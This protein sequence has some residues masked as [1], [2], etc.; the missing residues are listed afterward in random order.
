[1]TTAPKLPGSP[2]TGPFDSPSA[3]SPTG[4]TAVVLVLDDSPADRLAVGHWLEQAGFQVLEATTGAEALRLA[5]E[6]ADLIVLPDVHGLEVARRLKAEATTAQLPILHIATDGPVPV[7][8]AALLD[9]GADGYLAQ[10]VEPAELVASARALLRLGRTERALREQNVALVAAREVAERAQLQAEHAQ[11]ALERAAISDSRLLRLSAALSQVTSVEAAAATALTTGLDVLGAATG[12]VYLVDSAAGVAYLAAASGFPDTVVADFG[13]VPLDAMVP[14]SEVVRCSEAIILRSPEEMTARYPDLAPVWEAMT[15]RAL[16]VL[17]LAAA[18]RTIGT[19]GYAFDS[20]REFPAEELA[21]A[22]AVSQ[23]ASQALERARLFDAERH[24]RHDAEHANQVKTRFLA[25]ISHELR[26]PLNAVGGYAQLLELGMR[27]PVTAV[28]AED[29]RRIQ[30]SQAH[31]AGL[32]DA[33]LDYARV[34][35]GHVQYKT[36]DVPLA[37][38]LRSVATLVT[39]LLEARGIAYACAPYAPRVAVRADVEKLRQILVNLLTNAAKYT[40]RG[41]R[42]TLECEVLPGEADGAGGDASRGGALVALRVADTGIGIAPVL[43]AR[44]FEPFVQ[45]R[46]LS[47]PRDGVGLG[48]AISRDLARGMGGELTAESTPGVGST[49]TLTLPANRPA[50]G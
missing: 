16:V 39:P 12:G 49:F 42:V 26:T 22:T 4:G 11:R 32:L 37:D 38:C 46:E 24:A 19:L 7:D 8:P 14:T 28:Q 31:L 50:D 18:G 6:G 35:A 20:A 29:L 44:V 15:T 25:T 5:R 33:V 47:A 23:Q 41:G 36:V 40:P 21:F 1:M 17:P 13:A 9:A 27:G 43:L 2:A 3:S 10:P 30:Q 34:D 48:L 45:V